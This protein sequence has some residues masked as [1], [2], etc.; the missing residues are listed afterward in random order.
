MCLTCFGIE[1]YLLFRSWWSVSQTSVLQLCLPSSLQNCV[2]LSIF[3]SIFGTSS[4]FMYLPYIFY[5]YF[6]FVTV[7]IWKP[8]FLYGIKV[9]TVLNN[10]MREV[11]KSLIF[12]F[13]LCFSMPNS[14]WFPCCPLAPPPARISGMMW[15]CFW[16]WGGGFP[17]QFTFTGWNVK[18]LVMPFWTGTLLAVI[19]KLLEL[20][21]CKKLIWC[22]V[23]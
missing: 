7:R 17:L 14:Y 23:A 4:L 15:W 16:S 3:P 13:F 5:Q 6:F 8:R 1:G 19:P 20:E 18:L 9:N 22:R 12:G 2:V 21:W 11:E 10:K